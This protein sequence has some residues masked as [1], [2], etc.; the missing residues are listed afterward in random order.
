MKILFVSVRVD[1]FMGLGFAVGPVTTGAVAQWTG[2]I[3]T[4]LVVLCLGTVVGVVAGLF[5]PGQS[6]AEEK[7]ERN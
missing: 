1:P 2:A 4:G 7:L 3:Q 6:K 5:Y